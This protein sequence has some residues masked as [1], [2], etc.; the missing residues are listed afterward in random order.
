MQYNAKRNKYASSAIWVGIIILPTNTFGAR[1]I[2]ESSDSLLYP[3]Q[4]HLGRGQYWRHQTVCYTPN[5]CILGEGN[6]GGIRQSVIPPT[7]AFRVRAIL[8]SSVCW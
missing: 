5:K 3:Q 6:T 7:N 8:E 1:E 4:M 2:L